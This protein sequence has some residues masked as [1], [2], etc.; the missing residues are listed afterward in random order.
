MRI[1]ITCTL[2]H[3][4]IR[5][6]KINEEELG[7]ACTTHGRNEIIMHIKLW[8]E[9]LKGRDHLEELSVDRRIILERILREIWRKGVD[10][11]HLTARPHIKWRYYR[12]HYRSSHSRYGGF[13]S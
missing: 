6:I 9:N 7:G 8:S 10:W 5:V 13:C 12:S 11:M 4:I 3:I 1:F 2:H